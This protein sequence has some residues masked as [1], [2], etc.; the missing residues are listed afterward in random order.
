M[1]INDSGDDTYLQFNVAT[2]DN[3]AVKS[4]YFDDSFGL[5]GD[6]SDSSSYAFDFSGG[7]A[8]GGGVKFDPFAISTGNP[9]KDSLPSG[10]NI[11]FDTDFFSNAASPSGDDKNGIDNGEWLGITFFDTD[12]DLILSAIFSR[13]LVIG[14]HVGS[15][16]YE[17][18]FSESLTVVPV[19][20]AFWLFGTA[21][22]GFI[23][24][25]RRTKI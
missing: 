21:L 11:G 18:E 13:E 20:A 6:L 7:T 25:S 24:I 19:P 23:G 10:N 15:M 17:D 2:G 14:L 12:F 22:I 16:G 1:D 5:L 3:V 9:N 4:I 8:A